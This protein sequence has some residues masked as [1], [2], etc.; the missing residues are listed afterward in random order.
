[1]PKKRPIRVAPTREQRRQTRQLLG[2]LQDGLIHERTR[3]RYFA[4]V[5]HFTNFLAWTNLKHAT[6]LDG[7]DALVSLGWGRLE[8][9][10]RA[11]PLT[12]TFTYAIASYFKEKHWTDSLVLL[13]LGWETFARPGELFAARKR[14]FLL[15]ST[16]LQGTWVLPLSKSGQRHG[17][18]E[19]LTLS[20]PW[21]WCWLPRTYSV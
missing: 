7:L 18:A 3:K 8:L 6:T 13:L 12:P 9:P 4:A 10:V 11:P 16:R 15:S 14:D 5:E 19:S 20:D 21:S 2:S 17:A 1:M